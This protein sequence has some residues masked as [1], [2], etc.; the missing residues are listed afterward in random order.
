MAIQAYAAHEAG[1]KSIKFPANEPSCSIGKL[2]YSLSNTT[3]N[4]CFLVRSSC[5][6]RCDHA[7]KR[8]ENEQEKGEIKTLRIKK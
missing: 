2:H 6:R 1:G 3:D 7:K 8:E 5:Y 4:F